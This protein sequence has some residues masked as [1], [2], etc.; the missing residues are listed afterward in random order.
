MGNHHSHEKESVLKTNSGSGA[1]TPRGG[2]HRGSG[3][4]SGSGGDLQGLE[5][6]DKPPP[7]M[8]PVEKLAKV[9]WRANEQGRRQGYLSCFLVDG[10]FWPR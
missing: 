1:S 10:L 8:V 7:S 9:S 4:R 3:S 6:S 2:S 5:K